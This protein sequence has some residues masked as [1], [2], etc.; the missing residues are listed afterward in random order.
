MNKKVI[1]TLTALEQHVEEPPQI[2][3]I[4]GSGLGGLI[5]EIENA[6]RIRFED[7]PNFPVSSVVGHRGEVLFGIFCGVRLFAL[8]G[9][10]HYYEG[11]TTCCMV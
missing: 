2:G 4:L 8:S 10:V 3:I 1:E 6:V 11:Y 9:R 7:I 5:D